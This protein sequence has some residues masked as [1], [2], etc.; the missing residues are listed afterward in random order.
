MIIQARDKNFYVIHDEA[1]EQM[2]ED[3]SIHDNYLLRAI[4][5]NPEYFKGLCIYQLYNMNKTGYE[6]VQYHS[7]DDAVIID[8]VVYDVD[9]Y[10]STFDDI[11]AYQVKYLKL[12]DGSLAKLFIGFKMD[13]DLGCVDYLV[14]ELDTDQIYMERC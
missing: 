3:R 9:L 2:T 11:N 8:G 14:C 12:K 1:L 10:Q 5:D 6:K 4:Y 13:H 7:T